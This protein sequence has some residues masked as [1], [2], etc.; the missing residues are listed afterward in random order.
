[1][2][3]PG[4]ITID[5]YTMLQF[6]PPSNPLSLFLP[7]APLW[8]INTTHSNPSPHFQ[9]TLFLVISSPSTINCSANHHHNLLLLDSNP[10]PFKT[11]KPAPAAKL[12]PSSLFH[13]QSNTTPTPFPTPTHTRL[14]SWTHFTTFK[15][16]P[17]SYSC[18]RSAARRRL[19]LRSEPSPRNNDI[20]SPSLFN[21]TSINI[22]VNTPFLHLLTSV[23]TNRVYR[24]TAMKR[25]KQPSPP[26]QSRLL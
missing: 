12:S 24:P 11:P 16:I 19:H 9:P 26:T 7:A 25:R 23:H 21:Q 10:S 20:E 8:V 17:L 2:Q 13:F 1:M 6:N 4:Y 5:T 18:S 22:S 14:H 3:L 15:P